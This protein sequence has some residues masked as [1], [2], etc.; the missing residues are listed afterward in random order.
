M[1]ALSNPFHPSP[2]GPS[3]DAGERPFEHRG[4]PGCAWMVAWQGGDEAA[5][6]RLV[7]A[8]APRLY[9]LFTRFLGAVPGREDLVQEVFLRLIESRERYRASARFSTYLYRIAFNLS[10]HE[11]ERERLRW[12][13]PL[14]PR[15]SPE[16]DGRSAHAA[17]EH[18]DERAPRPAER[19]ERED[20]VGAVRRAIACLP[21]A[22]R[23]ALVLSKYEGL[24]HDEIALVM[25][26]TQK[27][28]KSL[29]H[30]AREALRVSLAGYLEEETA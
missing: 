24:A 6:D 20:V 9:A 4:D 8:Y 12:T 28:V 17:R 1:E 15:A 2:T 7:E 27:A 3:T 13:L 11:R 21:D 14:A 5:F 23:L 29:V 26:S 30:R 19:L 18:V 10:S 22:Q 25:G 16:H